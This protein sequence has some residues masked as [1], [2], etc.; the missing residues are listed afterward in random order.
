[1]RLSRAGFSDRFYLRRGGHS[2]FVNN[3]TKYGGGTPK[4]SGFVR[5][6]LVKMLAFSSYIMYNKLNV[7]FAPGGGFGGGYK[8]PFKAD[9]IR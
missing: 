2:G 1:M 3:F 9:L 6:I 8:Q 4:N 5:K 7:V